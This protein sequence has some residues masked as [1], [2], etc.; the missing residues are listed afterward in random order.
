[1]VGFCNASQQLLV[2]LVVPKR[3]PAFQILWATIEFARVRNGCPGIDRQYHVRPIRKGARR[4]TFEKSDRN[5]LRIC[6][7]AV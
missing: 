2:Q 1:M 7:P 6:D 3:F 4:V 5:D